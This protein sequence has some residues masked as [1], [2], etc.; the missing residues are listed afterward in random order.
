MY[1]SNSSIGSFDNIIIICNIIL[2]YLSV[3]CL[4][5]IVHSLHIIYIMYTRVPQFSVI[6]IILN[7]HDLELTINIFDSLLGEKKKL[8]TIQN[9][10]HNIVCMYKHCIILNTYAIF[11]NNTVLQNYFVCAR[12]KPQ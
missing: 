12:Y 7:G 9:N 2:Y 8:S 5:I 6:K 1:V 11:A 10:V 3:I 4:Y